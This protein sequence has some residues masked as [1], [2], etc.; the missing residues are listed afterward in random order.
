M[1]R[2]IPAARKRLRL[3]NSWIDVQSKT[4]RDAEVSREERKGIPILAREMGVGYNEKCRFECTQK[5]NEESR[6]SAFNE[7]GVFKI[8]QSSG[9]V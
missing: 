2:P 8:G 9:S 1:N 4:S 6:T 7:F 3:E 5:I